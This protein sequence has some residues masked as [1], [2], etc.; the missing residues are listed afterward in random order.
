M[1]NDPGKLIGIDVTERTLRGTAMCINVKMENFSFDIRGEYNIRVALGGTG[2]VR[3]ALFIME[4]GKESVKITGA[5]FG[6]GVGMCQSGARE[7]ARQGFDYKE[8]LSRYYAGV[9]VQKIV[10]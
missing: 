10:Y 2:V 5:G 8:I 3:S 1:C 7:L 4:F 9:V 6:H